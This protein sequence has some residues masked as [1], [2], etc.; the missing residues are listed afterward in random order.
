[1]LRSTNFR[2]SCALMAALLLQ[3]SSSSSNGRQV[4]IWLYD[5][6]HETLSALANHTDSFTAISPS[7]YRLGADSSGE[8]IM[9]GDGSS[10]VQ[11]IRSL[12]PGIAVWPWITS[13]DDFNST[14]EDSLMRRLFSH[15]EKFTAQAAA[16]A[17]SLHLDGFN[18]DFE[19]PGQAP[20]RNAT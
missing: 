13:P 20:N 1:M 18:V 15:P 11:S 2:V 7:L 12:L 10:C 19:A 5:C 14:A 3:T 9:T 17:A 6:S 16:T 8:A 4:L